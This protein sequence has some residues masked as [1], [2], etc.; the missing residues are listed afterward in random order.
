MGG[1]DT[2]GT[3]ICAVHVDGQ[4]FFAELTVSSTGQEVYGQSPGKLID[5]NW[6]LTRTWGAYW[7]GAQAGSGRDYIQF[8]FDETIDLAKIELSV[9][10]RDHDVVFYAYDEDNDTDTEIQRLK[11]T[12]DAEETDLVKKT[13]YF[14]GDA[15]TPGYA[16]K[17]FR[18]RSDNDGN[19]AFEIGEIHPFITARG[20]GRLGQ[21]NAMFILMQ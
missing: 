1:T 13:V 16:L 15:N 18:V 12:Y 21:G 2:N 6:A 7:F 20:A 10:N 19:N 9:D 17:A 14:F 3:K 4:H 11:V 8:A 5:D